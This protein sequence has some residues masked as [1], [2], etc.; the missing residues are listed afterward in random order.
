M[1][2]VKILAA[3]KELFEEKG[4]DRTTVREVATKAEANV[5][6]I[7]YH[8]G[9]KE[10]LL[11]SIVKEMTDQT[12][13]RL[14]DISNTT[15]DPIQKLNQVIDLYVERLHSNRNYYQ[16]I[17]REMSTR[18]LRPELHDLLSKI[19]RRNKDEIKKILENGQHKKVFRKD[20]DLDLVIS[21][22][23]GLMYQTTHS[24][25]REKIIGAK[26]DAEAFKER[27]KKHL[28]EMLK[29]YIVK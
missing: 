29:S 18:L 25:F 11:A 17:H 6:L 3:A 28:K 9:S 13:L 19:I 16:M 24:G 12:R 27:V 22:I 21:T 14:T 23:F 10:N 1:T 2:K 4:F 8:F 7:N 20:I 5:A 26:E 15:S